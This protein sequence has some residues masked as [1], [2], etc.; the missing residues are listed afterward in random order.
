MSSQVVNRIYVGNLPVGCEERDVNREFEKFGKISKLDIKRTVSGA[1]YA[2]IEYVDSR[3]AEDA[4][5]DRNGYDFDG[6]RL[7]VEVPFNARDG[8]GRNWRGR[9][10]PPRKGKY[11]IEVSGLPP[12]GSW[13][14]LKDHMREAGECGH[15][16]VFRDGTGEVSFFSVRDMEIAVEKFNGSVFR[17]HEGRLCICIA[18][19]AVKIC[20]SFSTGEKSRVTIREKTRGYSDGER[21]GGGRYNSRSRSY[22]YRRE[23]RD[24][25]RHDRY[26]K[27]HSRDHV[28]ERRRRSYSRSVER[29]RRYKKSDQTNGHTRRLSNE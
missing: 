27:R 3:D 15:A 1:P 11:V 22:E 4:I 29:D 28:E 26:D 5:K 9:G 25:D 6:S 23:S 24:H 14:D 8:R 17:S 12:S 21:G 16:D 7:R 19:A 20:C 10:Q 13:Q 2:F 18:K